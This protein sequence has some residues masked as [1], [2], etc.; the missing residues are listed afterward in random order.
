MNCNTQY[1]HR[2]AKYNHQQ[3]LG[4]FMCVH[5]VQ[6]LYTILH[7][8]DLTVFPPHNHHCSNDVYL[9]KGGTE[10]V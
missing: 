4:L 10:Y 2:K 9:R 8:T 1:N 3:L 5:R 7:R 6:L